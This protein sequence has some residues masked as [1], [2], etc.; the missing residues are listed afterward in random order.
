MPQLTAKL[1]KKGRGLENLLKQLK[2]LEKESVEIGHFQEQG[3]HTGSKMSYPGIMRLH[4]TGATIKTTGVVI[5]PRPILSILEFRLQGSGPQLKQAVKDWAKK[6]LSRESS[7]NLLEDIGKSVV[8]M[9]KDI[10]GD[11]SLLTPNSENT[12]KRVGVD[13]P[14]APLVD[15]GSLR[16]KVAYRTTIDNTVKGG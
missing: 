9:E 5:P 15:T 11:P 14:D 7:L 16:D 1:V 3:Q 13:G 4:H 6:S 10:F 8:V 12:R 2:D